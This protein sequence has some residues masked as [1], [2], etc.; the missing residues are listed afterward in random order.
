MQA[1]GVDRAMTPLEHLPA[2]DVVVVVGAN[3]P[4][5]FPLIMPLVTRARRRG[6]KFVVVDPR[7]SKLVKDDDIHLAVRPGTDTALAA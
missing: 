6:T 3:L 5:A 7:G 1:F 4:D 2:A